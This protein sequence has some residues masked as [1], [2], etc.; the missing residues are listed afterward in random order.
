MKF[1]RSAIE[2]EGA[3]VIGYENTTFKLAE[4]SSSSKKS[5][6]I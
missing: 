4:S 3:D 2:A 6:S 5:G 1:T